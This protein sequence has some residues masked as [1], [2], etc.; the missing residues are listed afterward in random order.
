MIL[1]QRCRVAESKISATLRL[2][3][4]FLSFIKINLLMM[5]FLNTDLILRSK[6]RIPVLI[7]VHPSYP[8]NP[9][10]LSFINTQYTIPLIKKPT[11][12]A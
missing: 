5:I 12:H 7:C 9:C 2:Y 4:Y 11:N 6:I 10:A 1:P 8:L 3:G